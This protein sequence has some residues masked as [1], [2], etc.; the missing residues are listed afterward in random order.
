MSATKRI[1][2]VSSPS[3]KTLVEATSQATAVKT[4][5]DQLYV[6]RIAKPAEIVELMQSG[7]KSELDHVNVL[8][9]ANA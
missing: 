8:A 1:Y 7:T 9:T 4:V 2:I 5:V 6:A 3:G